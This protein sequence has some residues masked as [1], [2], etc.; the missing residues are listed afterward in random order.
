MLG[1]DKR[2]LDASR[3]E[4]AAIDVPESYLDL[5]LVLLGCID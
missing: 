1:D 3:K 5:L 4:E 2:D